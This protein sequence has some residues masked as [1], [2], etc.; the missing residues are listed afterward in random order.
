MCTAVTCAACG[1]PSYVG[2]GEHV[3][4][5]LGGVPADERCRC[6]GEGQPSATP[7]LPRGFF[8]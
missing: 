8:A 3:E 4:Q 7:V 2:C 5:V 1:R 6:A